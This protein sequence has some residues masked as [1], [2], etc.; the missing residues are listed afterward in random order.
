MLHKV[1]GQNLLLPCTSPSTNHS[2]S[3]KNWH[4]FTE[5]LPKATFMQSVKMAVMLSEPKLEGTYH[6]TMGQDILEIQVI[7]ENLDKSAISVKHL[8]L[9]KWVCKCKRI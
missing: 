6:L 2:G 5:M 7:L 1:H 9:V 8:L 3:L 4:Q